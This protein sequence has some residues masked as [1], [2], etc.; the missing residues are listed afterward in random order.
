MMDYRQICEETISICI[1]TG[2]YIRKESKKFQKKQAHLKGYNSLVSYVDTQAEKMLVE[3]LRKLVPKA[4]FITEEGTVNAAQGDLTWVIDPLDGTTN[5]VFGVPVYSISVALL[6]NQ[7]PVVGVVLEITRKECFFAYKSGGAYMNGK[8]IQVS[9]NNKLAE[10]LIATGF[11]YNYFDRMDDYMIIFRQ[12]LQKTRGVRRLGSASVDLAYVA[13]GRFDAFYEHN[14]NSWDVAAGA[15]I[16]RQAGGKV[17]DFDG[18]EDFVFG[19]QILAAT[20]GIHQHIL[21][22]IKSYF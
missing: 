1:S 8:S 15:F 14:L 7:M 13:C 5:F 10:S 19:N 12:L 21:E 6:E 9:D 4:T 18:G 11:P 22:L 17:S 16:V 2:K 3:S 20:P